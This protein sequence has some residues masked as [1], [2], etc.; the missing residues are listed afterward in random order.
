MKKKV[1]ISILIILVIIVITIFLI[2][3]NK[4]SNKLKRYLKHNGYTCNETICFYENE[5]NKYQINY[6][7]GDY[8]VSGNLELEIHPLYNTATF[9]GNSV[10]SVPYQCHYKHEGATELTVFT[11]DDTA[12][13]CTEFL[14]IVNGE[15]E[16]YQTIAVKSK[17]DLSKLK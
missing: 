14:G 10:T 11:E 9:F 4:D 1:L 13:Y 6:H 17:T 12:S 7:N 15:V 8:K 5:G 3:F 2:I 16:N